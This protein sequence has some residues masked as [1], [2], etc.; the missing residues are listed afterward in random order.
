MGQNRGRGHWILS[1]NDSFLL[2]RPKRL[3]KI[4]LRSNKNCVHRSAGSQTDRQKDT[5]DF[6]ICSVLCYSNG[7]DKNRQ[8]VTETYFKLPYFC[9]KLTARF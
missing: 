9:R 7:T 6:I 2:F 8:Y 4:S 3:C 5:S 1:P